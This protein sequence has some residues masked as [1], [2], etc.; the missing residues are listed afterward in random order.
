M[1]ISFYYDDDI[2]LQT[3][4]MTPASGILKLMEALAAHPKIVD[5]PKKNANLL[6]TRLK[7][8]PV[9]KVVVP[10]AT[11]V[12]PPTTS[13]S[14]LSSPLPSAKQSKRAHVMFSYCWRQAAKPE[15]VK[16]LSARLK[17][18]GYDIW[19]DEVKTKQ[20]NYFILYYVH[21]C[22]T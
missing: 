7:A 10:P 11:I 4:L 3:K 17:Q 19:R 16:R 21:I 2:D 1:Q 18:L 9:P 6:I 5:E 20:N 22:S 13:S 15:F 8:K 12:A 14:A